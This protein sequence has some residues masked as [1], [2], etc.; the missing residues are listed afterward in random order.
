MALPGIVLLALLRE[1]VF[2]FSGVCRFIA[3]R[4][5]PLAPSAPSPYQGKAYTGGGKAR[6]IMLYRASRLIFLCA[7][8]W[9]FCQC[10]ATKP[11]LVMEDAQ[12]IVLRYVEDHGD[13][14]KCC[15]KETV[16]GWKDKNKFV[17]TMKGCR[18]PCE[19]RVGI[20]GRDAGKVESVT[21]P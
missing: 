3:F 21:C 1:I 5:D 20:E 15:D 13:L 4:F 17:F 10:A 16:I 9:A 11:T 2:S 6:M 14:S 8:A 19:I 18:C 7:V 12:G